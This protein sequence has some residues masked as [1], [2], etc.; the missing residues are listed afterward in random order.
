MCDVI[1]KCVH[2]GEEIQIDINNINGISLCKDKYYHT[3]CLNELAQTKIQSKRHAS[4]WDIAVENPHVYENDAISTIKTKFYRDK[5]N[6]HLLKYYDVVSVSQWFWN[7]ISELGNGNYRKKKC[8]PVDVELIYHTWVWGQRKLNT[9]ALNNKKNHKGPVNDEQR[10]NYDL[11]IIVSKIPNYL[12]YKKKSD[13]EEAERK[14]AQEDKVK[15]N[16]NNV[17]QSTGTQNHGLD[18]ISSLL[19]EIF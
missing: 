6:K 19:D 12:A 3:H 8:K 18:D 9:I 7:V 2:C 4:Y 11:S 17:A 16:Y 13:A 5:L 10:L 15:I 1:K 14:K